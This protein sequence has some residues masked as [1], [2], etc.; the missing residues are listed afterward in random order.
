MNIG[1]LLFPSVTQLDLTGPAEVFGR[2]EGARVH[3]IARTMDPVETGGGWKILPTATY[4]AAPQLDVLCVPGGSGQIALMED[5]ET[6][7]FLRRQA[8]GARYVTSVCTG[9]LLLG[10]AGLLKGYRAACHWMS[11][12]Q[13]ALLGALSSDERIVIDRNRITGGGVSAGIDFAL[14]VVAELRGEEAAR[15]IQLE[16][17]YDPLPPF[18]GPADPAL[19]E[20]VRRA[21]ADRQAKRLAATKAAARRLG[22]D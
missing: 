5:A 16:I 19:V 14:R 10:A 12:D 8:A 1:L 22:R 2:V 21:A 13:L 4:A 6:L 18:P 11:R 15:A 20:R 9:S 7:D 17:E 3:L